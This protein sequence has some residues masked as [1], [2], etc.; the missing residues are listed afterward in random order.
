MRP[1]AV[2]SLPPVTN[3]PPDLEPGPV[4]AGVQAEIHGVVDARPGLAQVALSLARLMD[5]PKVKNTQPAAAKVLVSVLSQ[6]HSESGR[7][8]RGNLKLVRSMT[9]KGGA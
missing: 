8:G 3:V 9:E 1:R 6:L 5:D 2:A 7:Q 4:E